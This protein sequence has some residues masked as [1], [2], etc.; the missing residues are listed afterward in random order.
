MKKYERILSRL[1]HIL[2]FVLKSESTDSHKNAFNGAIFSAKCA[3]KSA[4]ASDDKTKDG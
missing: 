1:E 4:K 3:K 2:D